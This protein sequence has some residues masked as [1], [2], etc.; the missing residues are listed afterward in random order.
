MP[1]YRSPGCKDHPKHPLYRT[2]TAWLRMRQRCR[3]PK[4]RVYRWYGGRGISICERWESFDNF[5]EDMGKVPEGLELDRIDSNGHYEPS[6]CRY[7][8]RITQIKNRRNSKWF[9]IE[10][11]TKL[12][13]EWSDIYGYN[14][15]TAY[16]R[17]KRTGDFRSKK[18]LEENYVP[19]S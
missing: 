1:K 19:Q 9:T 10:G 16:V 12:V 2:Y 6:N 13:S 17:L 11:E 15:S 7:V 14:R 4:A 3:N 8:D 18:H 5:L